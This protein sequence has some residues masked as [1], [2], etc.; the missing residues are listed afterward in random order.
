[1]TTPETEA[2]VACSD[3]HWIHLWGEFNRQTRGDLVRVQTPAIT[4]V[5]RC[6]GGKWPHDLFVEGKRPGRNW[7]QV[8]RPALFEFLNAHGKTC[9]KDHV[10][11]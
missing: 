11:G 3:D 5:I 8:N 9:G 6:G 1:M 10:H 7:A 4:D 2:H